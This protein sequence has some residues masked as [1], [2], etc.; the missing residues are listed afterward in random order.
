MIVVTGA[1]GKLGGAVVTQLL[2]RVS[3]DQIAVSVRDPEKVGALADRG[4]DVRHGDNDDPESLVRAFDGASTVLIVSLPRWGDEAVAA[5]RTAIDAARRASVGRILYTSH[6]GADLL[7]AFDP[8]VVH[9]RTEA[10]LLEAGVPFTTLRDGFYTDT[11]I[12]WAQQAR[13]TGEMRFPEDGPVSWT[14]REDIAAAIAALLADETLDQRIVNLTAGEAVD[15]AQLAAITSD[16][17]G[18]DIRRVTVPDDEF[19]RSMIDAGTPEQGARVVLSIIAASRERRMSV[20]DPAL[21]Q[22]AGRPATPIR[23]VLAD[24]L[25]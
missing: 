19:V 15:I 10:Y 4:V 8:C 13:D 6:A 9:A 5:N 17:T 25:A 22:L 11:P 21:A 12:R 7:S 2:E 24:A 3:A 23:D 1:T 18:R 16:L 14:T 20:V